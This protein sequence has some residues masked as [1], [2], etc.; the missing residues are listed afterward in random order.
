MRQYIPSV[1]PDKNGLLK[2]SGKDYR[3]MRNVLRLRTGDMVSVRLPD[4]TLRA[5][6]VCRVDEKKHTML[7]QVCDSGTAG[8]LP[9]AVFS[10]NQPASAVQK[11][12][13]E[14]YLMQFVPK[15]QKMDLIIRQAVECGVTAVI[16][17][18]GEYSS[19]A[20][21]SALDSRRGRLEK[22][23]REARQQ[24]G[25][26][27]D[28]CVHAAINLPEMIDFWQKLMGP[29]PEATAAVVLYERTDRTKSLYRAFE[30]T[31]DLKKIALVV[32]SEGGISPAEI[33]LLEKAGFTL[34]HFD[35]NILRCET[36]ALYGT[37]A[38]RTAVGGYSLWRNKE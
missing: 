18:I 15:P 1:F 24:S 23:I 34:V 3:Y 14:Y 30:S 12:A 36:A 20:S 25:S 7:L 6:T 16:P 17:V 13:A 9:A 32:G 2:V 4:G 33:L 26:P 21:V 38:V 11:S 37:A 5:M 22:I 29:E 31:T 28:T 19:P 35:T 8:T 27:V 10:N